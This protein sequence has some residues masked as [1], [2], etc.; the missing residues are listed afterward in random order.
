MTLLLRSVLPATCLV[1]GAMFLLDGLRTAWHG[2]PGVCDKH[3]HTTLELGIFVALG[4]T[5]A[6]VGIAM[7]WLSRRL[8]SKPSVTSIYLA[9]LCALFGATSIA[10]QLPGV[11][12]DTSKC[13]WAV[14]L[15]SLFWLVCPRL[16]RLYQIEAAPEP[17][18]LHLGITIFSLSAWMLFLPTINLQHIQQ[19]QGRWT[20]VAVLCSVVALTI[21]L[22]KSMKRWHRRGMPTYDVLKVAGVAGVV[23][24]ATDLAY[25]T[26]WPNPLEPIVI[27][28]GQAVPQRSRETMVRWPEF[29][30]KFAVWDD[31][32]GTQKISK[33]VGASKASVN[34]VY[35]A[36]NGETLTWSANIKG[37]GSLVVLFGDLEYDLS[38]GSTVFLSTSKADK[39]EVESVSHGDA[40]SRNYGWYDDVDDSF[41]FYERL[42]VLE[43]GSEEWIGYISILF[44]PNTWSNSPFSGAPGGLKPSVRIADMN[45]GTH[46]ITREA[47]ENAVVF[48]GLVDCENGDE[49]SWKITAE[50]EGKNRFF[51]PDAVVIDGETYRRPQGQYFEISQTGSGL[52]VARDILRHSHQRR[53]LGVTTQKP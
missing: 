52:T 25:Q 28:Q 53:Y 47:D 10:P 37:D 15:W 7:I 4:I 48:R 51:S 43:P 20:G 6:A 2:V 8:W 46:H 21:W 1:V 27:Q 29:D 50:R 44:K 38:R 11:T 42:R 32:Q 16:P 41:M 35:R 12:H 19:G 17:S 3:V 36:A 13:L 49:W 45:D 9:G 14:A 39:I 23:M 40:E 24:L 31:G 34:G 5:V 22:F 33:A 26:W 30:A 18:R